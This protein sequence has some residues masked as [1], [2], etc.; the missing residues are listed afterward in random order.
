M[1]TLINVN[2]DEEISVFGVGYCGV[3]GVSSCYLHIPRKGEIISLLDKEFLVIE[4]ETVL[5][6]D[7][8]LKKYI[9]TGK[10]ATISTVK[11]FVEDK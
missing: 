11:I 8:C 1:I 9:T 10:A 3:N 4:V 6:E 2:S 7:A 5:E